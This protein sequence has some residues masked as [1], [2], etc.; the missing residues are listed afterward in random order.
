MCSLRNSLLPLLVAASCFCAR[1]QEP[2]TLFNEKLDRSLISERL[3]RPMLENRQGISGVVNV[4]KI[5]AVPS[6]LGNADPIRFV[7]LLP[8]VQLSTEL[9]GGLYMQGSESSMTLVSQQGVPL[10]GIAHL[11]GL[12][13]VFNS[14]HFRGMQYDTSA[15]QEARLAGKVDIQL[16]DTLVHRVRGDFSVGMLSAQGTLA[17]PT[18]P[19]ASLFLSARRTF[20][21]TVYGNLL[22]Y[23]DYPLRYGFTDANLTWLWKPTDRDRVWVDL[24]GCLDHGQVSAG[25]ISNM[26]AK[27]YNAIGA[28]HWNHY[29]SGA[30][31]KQR[32]YFTT[33]GL[34]PEVLAF[35]AYGQMPSYIQDYGYRGNLQWNG[36]D[37]GAH[38]SYYRIQPQNPMALGHFSDAGNRGDEPVQNAV[39]TILSAQYSR[40]IG[41]WLEMK[42][43]AGVHWYLS[44]EGRSYFGIT[45]EAALSANLMEGGT[46]ELRYGIKRQ[47]LFQ[48]G[49][50]NVGLPCEFWLAAG[51][52]QD[53][54]WSHNFT[55]SYNVSLPGDAFSVS[56]E[57]Y[58][59]QLHNQLEYVGSILDIYTGH[60]S[61]ES[62]IARGKGRAFGANVMF[63]KQTGKLTGWVSY[64]F[65]RSLR[66][67]DRDARAGE[68][69]SAHERLHE[70]DVVA[71]YD[72]GRFD[73]GGTY[74][75]ASGAPY[76]PPASIV[77]LGGRILCEYGAYN[78]ARLPAYS[79][80]DIS[81][82]WYIKKGPRGKMGLNF[83]MYNVLGKKNEL[84]YGM[85][86]NPD[87][88]AY[89]FQ[90]SGIQL[91]FLPA[92][93]FFMTF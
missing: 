59:R 28:L 72:F 46:L 12:F 16:Q 37:F 19:R 48:L 67:F 83:S 23:E 74:V 17:V 93:A 52:F 82:N 1:A 57:L 92:L 8:S 14:P 89:S 60:Y 40:L 33:F 7:R 61:L 10:Y 81:A 36:W 41:Y 32:A 73:V 34:H 2:D 45:P 62:S 22:K 80:L 31:L 75:L 55:L 42:A 38:V 25:L 13:S 20:I 85:H 53:P 63:Q 91:R 68:Y 90:T 64:A 84:G 86:I 4:E 27:W 79:R 3:E 70:L 35:N 54:Q 56:T 5:A 43:V 39:E 87:F 21:N 58:Y 66:T 76:T 47:N 26:E 18:G 78:S 6:F 30:T 9:E 44:P 71:T 11:L 15:G 69:P 29:F 51:K 65:S 49:F 24:F 77:L 88:T 50:T